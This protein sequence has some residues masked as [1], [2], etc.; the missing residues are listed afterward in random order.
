MDLTISFAGTTPVYLKMDTEEPLLL[1][2]G[3]CRQLGII[4]YHPEVEVHT[5]KERQKAAAATGAEKTDEPTDKPLED[6]VVHMISVRLVN[7]LKLLPSHF[8]VVTVE[9][10]GVS[11]EGPKML[12]RNLS[13]K[14]ELGL[15]LADGVLQVSND[16]G[17]HVM[18][19]NNLGFTQQVAPGTELGQVVDAVIVTDDEVPTFTMSDSMSLTIDSSHGAELCG[20]SRIDVSDDDRKRRL[21]EML[22]VSGIPDPNHVEYLKNFLAEY[23][24]AFSIDPGERG[25]TEL[26]QVEVDT[27][28]ASP[29][30]Q[31][32]RHMP[33][34][35]RQEVGKHLNDMQQ[36]G[37]IQPS[38]S[39]WASP[40][41]M[42]RKDGSHRFCVD[43]RLLNAVTKPDL[44]PLP[45][46]DDLLDQ[47]GK[48]HYFSTLDLASGYWQIQVHPNSI[49][50][51]AFITPQGLFEFRVMPFGLMNAPSVFQR[52]MS[53]VLMGLNPESGPDFVAVYIDDVLSLLTDTS[54]PHSLFEVGDRTSPGGWTET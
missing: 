25:E 26:V 44:Y 19:V 53:R 3:V 24:Q 30:R 48:S 27:G 45:R 49:E 4:Q 11:A 18:L 34:A 1:S 5:L 22:D 9:V 28:T 50:K 7:S 35:V 14:D 23:H 51:T 37:V 21:L 31:P 36:S 41:V 6:A 33:F 17:T 16:G 32:V 42:V 38:S 13:V 2:E 46:I 52:L 29:R 54:R 15:E 40:V 8:A 10:D 12:E 47:L 20:V 39:P 43:Y